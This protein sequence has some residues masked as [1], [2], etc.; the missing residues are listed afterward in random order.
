MRLFLLTQRNVYNYNSPW[1]P[2]KNKVSEMVVLANN[3]KEARQL[4]SDNAEDENK[5]RKPWKD[6]Y[7]SSCT[8]LKNEPQVINRIIKF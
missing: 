2:E 8:I 7:W 4:A 1:Y 6:K 3:E 5:R